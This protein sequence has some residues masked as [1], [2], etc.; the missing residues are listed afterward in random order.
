M[1]FL[2]TGCGDQRTL[3]VDANTG[4]V[5]WD[6]D[7]TLDGGERIPI[8]GNGADVTEISIQGNGRACWVI[9]NRGKTG[10]IAAYLKVSSVLGTDR[11]SEKSSA[12]PYGIVIACSD[13]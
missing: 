2:L 3:V 1:A 6:G 4:V 7:Y 10:T 8:D 13:D 12:A 5:R 9:A 11:R